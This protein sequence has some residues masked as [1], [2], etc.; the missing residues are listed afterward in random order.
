MAVRP[1]FN[2][3]NFLCNLCIYYRNWM[4]NIK[5]YCKSSNKA[6]AFIRII[7]FHGEG[8]GRLLEASVFTNYTWTTKNPYVCFL[9]SITW[10]TKNVCQLNQWL[11]VTT[12]IIC[13]IT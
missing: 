7:T 5:W 2:N 12:C 3:I 4:I 10:L 11:K 13:L 9:W 1:L 6:R 8:D